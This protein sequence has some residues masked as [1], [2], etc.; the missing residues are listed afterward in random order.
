[1]RTVW[2]LID[3]SPEHLIKEVRLGFACVH[4]ALLPG[5]CQEH[6]SFT[7]HQKFKSH[8]ISFIIL[9]SMPKQA[10]YMVLQI[11]I[12]DDSSDARWLVGDHLERYVQNAFP[13]RPWGKLVGIGMHLVG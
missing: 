6:D 10:D 8:M 3:E 9:M 12:V 1:M 13:R 11:F 4:F 5:V 2:S 7:L